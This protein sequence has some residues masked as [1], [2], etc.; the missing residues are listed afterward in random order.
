MSSP[1][2][3]APVVSPA[4]SMISL[5]MEVHKDS[6]TIAVLPGSAKTPTRLERLPND[7]PPLKQWIAR[8]A[9]DGAVHAC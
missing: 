9:R 5:G 8:V 7:L 6:S 3:A 1:A 2:A 4:R